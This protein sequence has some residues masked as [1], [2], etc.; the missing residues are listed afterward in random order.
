MTKDSVNELKKVLLDLLGQKNRLSVHKSLIYFSGSI[1]RAIVLDQIIFW[2]DKST[3]DEEGWFHKSY[4]EWQ[5]EITIPKTTLVRIF[6]HFESLDFMERKTKVVRGVRK[7]FIKANVSKIINQLVLFSHQST[8]VALC[9]KKSAETNE[10]RCIKVAPKYQSGTLQSTKMALSYKEQNK[11]TQ[12]RDLNPLE[13]SEKPCLLMDEIQP[14][15]LPP[16]QDLESTQLTTTTE[17]EEMIDTSYQYPETYYP[18]KIEEVKEKSKKN[19]NGFDYFWELY[20]MQQNE[21]GARK[22]W[23]R[24]KCELIAQEIILALMKQIQEDDKFKDGY[25]PSPERYLINKRWNDVPFKRKSRT[26]LEPL[27]HKDHS[28]AKGIEKD[29]L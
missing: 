7:L 9:S 19:K 10:N 18:A 14:I 21:V 3:D 26:K 8:K 22:A 29:I 5:E 20:P 25:I 11:H 4:E 12:L 2:S 24:G 16:E 23:A 17:G 27:D 1:E 13:K 15:N 6:L 28:Y